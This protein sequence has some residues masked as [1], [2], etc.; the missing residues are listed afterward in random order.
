MNCEDFNVKFVIMNEGEKERR[1]G[2]REIEVEEVLWAFNNA[3]GMNILKIPRNYCKKSKF[4]SIK[5]SANRF[6]IHRCAEG[7]DLG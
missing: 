1:K 5:S 3:P 6:S 7:T 4:I 2:E